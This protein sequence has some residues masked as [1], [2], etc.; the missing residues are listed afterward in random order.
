LALMPGR[1]RRRDAV[2]R[3][4]STTRSNQLKENR[5]D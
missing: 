1:T 2:P 3:R 5:N 4:T